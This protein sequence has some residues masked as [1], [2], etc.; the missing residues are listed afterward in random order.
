[1]H[2]LNETAPRWERRFNSSSNSDGLVL[3]V[4]LRR[5]IA[6]TPAKPAPKIDNVK[7]SDTCPTVIVRLPAP[8]ITPSMPL[9]LMA[10]IDRPSTEPSLMVTGA[11]VFQVIVPLSV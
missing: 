8:P 10:A 6:T 2:F 9:N 7:G 11:M 3:R 1:M 5:R 4:L